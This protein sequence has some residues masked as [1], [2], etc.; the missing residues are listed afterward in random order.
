[1]MKT[2]LKAASLAVLAVATAANAQEQAAAESDSIEIVVTAQKRS[3][4]IQDV[5]VAVS[6]VTGQQLENLGAVNIEG[7][8][9]LVPSLTFRKGGTSL[10]SSLFL[11][12]VGTINFSIAAEPSV[13][14]VLDGVVLARAGEGFGDLYDLERIEVLRGPQGTLFGKNASA[15]VVNIVS[16]RPEAEFGGSVELGAFE[17]GEYK[18]K[19]MVNAPLSDTVRSR[20][21]AFYGEYDGNIRNLTT[22][23][24]INGYKRYGVRAVV[25]ADASETLK[26]TAI[27]DWR[28]ADDD[29]C[30]EVIG[31]A[32]TGAASGTLPG[33]NFAGDGVRQV[34]NN[35]VTRTEEE[36]WGVS[37]QGDLE[38]GDHTLTSITSYRKWDNREIRE[39]DWLDRVYVGVAQLHDDGPQKADTLTQELRLTSPTG[40]MFEYVVG[41]YYY[42]AD[43][44]RTFTRNVITCTASTSPAVTGGTAV[45]CLAGTSTTTNISGTATFGSTF[46]NMAL[47]GQGTINVSDA[48]RVIAGLRFTSDDLSTFHSR[49]VTATGPGIAANFAFTGETDKTNLSGKAGVQYDVNDDTMAYATYSRGYKG[50]AFNTFFNMGATATNVIDAE[51]VDA[52]E[53]GI[54]TKLLDGRVL[55]N[56]AGFYA[57]YK[58]F[59]ANN[60]DLIAGVVVTRLTNAG[61]VSTRGL[62]IDFLARAGEGMTISGGAAWTDAQVDQFRLPPGAAPTAVVPSGNP[63]ALSPK[64]K[65]SLAVDQKIETESM[66]F[67]W[68]FGV[69]TSYQS[70]QLSFFDANAANQRAGTIDNYALVDLSVGITAKNDM[71]SLRGVVKNLFDQS[72]TSLITTGGPGGSLRYLIPREADRYVGATLK[73]NF[74]TGR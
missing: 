23:Q 28:K 48:F 1:M 46:E 29:C 10:N 54:K 16:K 39:G 6:V 59:Q 34:R 38:M 7:A 37:L 2:Y 31:T 51:T 35:L 63:L 49:T 53:V 70:K 58:N 25:E 61:S 40:Q 43:A 74:G 3:E 33:V 41:G 60:P 5:P 68:N 44:E 4:S 66:P 55:F 14:V 42:R 62:E 24:D 20:I 17:G 18:A 52:G 67:D 30:G 69:Q 72:F 56:V 71:W 26:L 9:A 45:P 21:T 13:A 32:P 73:V 19:A 15:G 47:F 12:G 57:K 22:G 11:R 64:F 8:T 27:A 36:A 65:A 50:P